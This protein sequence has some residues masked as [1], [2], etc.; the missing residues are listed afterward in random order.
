MHNSSFSVETLP[1]AGSLSLARGVERVTLSH[2]RCYEIFSVSLDT[3]S[4]VITGPNGAGKTNL[5][6]ALSFLI[7]GRGLR[8]ARLGEIKQQGNPTPWA[9]S[10]HLQDQAEKIQIG[11]GLDPENPEIERRVTRING[12]KTKSQSTLAEWVSMVWLTPQMDRLFLDGAQGRRRFL[13]RLVYGF[14]PNHAVRLNRYER[15]LRERSLLLRQGRTDRHWLEGL[16]DILVNDGIAITAARHEI[17]GQLS[18]VLK[19]QDSVFP[20]AEISLK[21]DIENLLL[22]GSLLAAEEEMRQLLQ[23]SREQDHFSG[24]TSYG[25]HRS[26]LDVTFLEKNQPAALCSTGEQKALLLSIVM[27]SAHLLSVRTG[28]IPLLLLDEV[29]AHLDKKR[30]SALFDAI[31][32]L[33]IQTWLTGTDIALFEELQGSVQFLSLSEA[34]LV[35]KT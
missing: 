29:V 9:I 17:V 25:P 11:T 8:R 26:D 35:S 34:R 15:A 12:E 19:N 4:V 22:E 1:N 18:H 20:P 3:R 16:E 27:A 13:D 30:R 33:R 24:R 7:P 21:G 14:D 2:F 32:K 5:L 28:A 31:L 10:I 6:E 23:K